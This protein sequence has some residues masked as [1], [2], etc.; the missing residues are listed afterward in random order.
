MG[1]V[2]MILA[3]IAAIWSYLD[4]SKLKVRSYDFAAH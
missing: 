4:S 1:I 2:V 3:T